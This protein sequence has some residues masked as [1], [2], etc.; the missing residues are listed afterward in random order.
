MLC[1]VVVMRYVCQLNTDS[2]LTTPIS[3]TTAG[4]Q[5]TCCA[6]DS[7]NVPDVVLLGGS[8]ILIYEL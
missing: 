6:A 2:I 3:R 1:V 5:Y 8:Q 4:K 7:G